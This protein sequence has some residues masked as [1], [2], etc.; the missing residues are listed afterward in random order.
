MVS[1]ENV[2][3][4]QREYSVEDG[5]LITQQMGHSKVVEA[6]NGQRDHHN[7]PHLRQAYSMSKD[8]RH[9]LLGIMD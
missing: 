1:A 3:T 6:D 4:T 7:N 2:W 9:E 5:D 8:S